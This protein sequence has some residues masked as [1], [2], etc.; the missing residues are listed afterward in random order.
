MLQTKIQDDLKNAIKTQ[1]G[2]VKDILRVV[3]GDM[4]RV[5]KE[6]T[7]DQVLKV[8]KYARDNAIIMNNQV[9]IDILNEY[10][11]KN[12]SDSELNDA[13]DAIITAG[14]YSGMKDMGKVVNELRTKYTGQFDGAIASGIVKSKLT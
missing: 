1:N 9:E 8:V 5:G 7:D 4:N 2:P 3:I 10:F 12:L 14:N 6:L 11:P 13:I